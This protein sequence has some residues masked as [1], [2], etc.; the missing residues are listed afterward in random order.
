ML[1]KNPS[2]SILDDAADWAPGRYMA[3]LLAIALIL[4]LLP[5]ASSLITHFPDERH[6]SNGAVIML[7]TGEY[8]TPHTAEGNVRLKKPPFTY[9]MSA[10]GMKVFGIS[11]L[12]SRF[13]WLVAGAATL[14]ITFSLTRI[15]THNDRTA[16]LAAS[17]LATNAV[18]LRACINAIPD[19]P[20][21]MFMLIGMLGFVGL[22]FR[23]GHRHVY[24]I[25][26][27]AGTG[28][29]ILAKGL[30]PVA[31]LGYILVYCMAMPALRQRRHRLW[32]PV[33]ITVCLGIVGT[34]FIYQSLHTA[35]ML[36]A[37]FV[38]DQI[39]DKINFNPDII[40]M[41]LIHS[42]A[43]L[44]GPTFVWLG[45]LFYG[46]R[47]AGRRPEMDSLNGITPFFLG[48]IIA[49][50]IIF[51]LNSLPS[52]RYVIPVIP[53]L[54]VLL[55][56][57][58]QEVTGPG[59]ERLV[60]RVLRVIILIAAIPIT[61]VFLIG[62]QLLPPLYVTGLAAGIAGVMATLWVV[63]TRLKM[64]GLAASAALLAMASIVTVTPV[65]KALLVP[66]IGKPLAARINTMHLPENE[67]LFV[68]PVLDAA[69]IRLHA[70]FD[71][72]FKQTAVLPSKEIDP[73]VKVILMTDKHL[74]D[75]LAAQ[76][77]AVEEV[78]AGWRRIHLQDFISA[79]KT[80]TLSEARDRYG[81]RGYVAIRS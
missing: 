17:L 33:T 42:F 53:L 9:W 72:Q 70:D 60:Q 64:H 22:L 67:V 36:S 79:L 76:G 45:L 65:A 41:G 55:A 46:A 8:L 6:Y 44:V 12:G 69:K 24:G 57:G 5:L 75:A 77:F 26:A 27:Y 18:F 20:L 15:I 78:T 61:G 28:L 13:L 10:A 66:D 4:S 43:G 2:L 56:C 54:C 52:H 80:G 21:T 11:V 58:F 3:I 74:A 38:A 25:L 32:Q 51:S 47:K 7:H 39:S 37:D 50:S 30:L 49:V 35:S 59:F 81:E 1:Q 34:W 62:M 68:G 31:M 16:L 29:A 73:G 71:A 40:A 63:N 48:W 23:D 19:M 14:L